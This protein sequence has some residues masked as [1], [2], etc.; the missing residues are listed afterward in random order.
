M[1][2]CVESDEGCERVKFLF[3][4]ECGYMNKSVRQSLLPLPNHDHQSSLMALSSTRTASELPSN[5]INDI[6]LYLFTGSDV[7]C[8][9]A[10]TT[11]IQNDFMNPNDLLEN[12]G[13]GIAGVERAKRH[14]NLV[15]TTKSPSLEE[16]KYKGF[17]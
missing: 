10:A 16:L 17:P 2:E 6:L 5:D 8:G 3:P 1:K 9:L 12:G 13:S 4:I 7:D 14:F 15:K 11:S